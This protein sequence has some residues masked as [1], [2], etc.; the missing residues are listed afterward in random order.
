MADAPKMSEAIEA[1]CW[2]HRLYGPES[3]LGGVSMDALVEAFAR[4]AESPGGRKT[5]ECI[6]RSCGAA[7]AKMTALEL[8][9]HFNR[10][11]RVAHYGYDIDWSFMRQVCRVVKCRREDDDETDV[12]E[13]AD[14]HA[15]IDALAERWDAEFGRR[16][17]GRAD[18]TGA[19]YKKAQRS[20]TRSKTL[21]LAAAV[22]KMG[23]AEAARR[24]GPRA[25]DAAAV[26]INGLFRRRMDRHRGEMQAILYWPTRHLLDAAENGGFYRE[27]RDVLRSRVAPSE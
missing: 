14:E 16:R 5:V 22:L 17:D 11:H 26:E 23:R 2:L 8:A 6:S 4:D 24:L 25:L 27:L 1:I 3:L 13:A 20:V 7:G 21:R 19:E 15:G 10:R 9:C 12:E 18:L